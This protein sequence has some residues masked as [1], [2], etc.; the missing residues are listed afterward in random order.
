MSE[1]HNFRKYEF[2]L[3]FL[4]FKEFEVNKLAEKILTDFANKIIDKKQMSIFLN[5]IYSKH[6]STEVLL[7][8]FRLLK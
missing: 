4:H 8:T 5:Q 2:F 1:E 6:L 3:F 7:F